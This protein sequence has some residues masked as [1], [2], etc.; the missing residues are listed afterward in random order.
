MASFF[1]VFVFFLYSMLM[2]HPEIEKA[3][4]GEISILGMVIA[5][6][7]LVIFSWFFIFYSLK[8]I[9]FRI[10]EQKRMFS[11]DDQFFLSEPLPFQ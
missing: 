3:V 10:S 2:F 11:I 7:V 4:L 1:S 8:V 6:F 9:L 5:E